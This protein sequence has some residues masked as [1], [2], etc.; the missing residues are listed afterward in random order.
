MGFL[1][2]MKRKAT[3]RMSTPEEP[4][5]RTLP[6]PGEEPVDELPLTPESRKIG[7]EERDR[8]A[9]GVTAVEAEG[10]DLDLSL[11]HI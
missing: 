3:E 5:V 10:V 7:D 9:S 11:I 8:I 1:D 2:R 4:R 6:D